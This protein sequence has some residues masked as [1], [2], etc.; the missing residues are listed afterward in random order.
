MPRTRKLKPKEVKTERHVVVCAFVIETLEG[1]DITNAEA[2][3]VIPNLV[4]EIDEK[5][6][7]SIRRNGH[8]LLYAVKDITMF[9]ERGFMFEARKHGFPRQFPDVYVDGPP[10]EMTVSRLRS[11]PRPKKRKIKIK[12]H[13][14]QEAAR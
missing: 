11:T 2:S 9:T 14:E 1:T 5:L 12:K 4:D 3:G 7:A 13:T 6:G 10:K 8:G